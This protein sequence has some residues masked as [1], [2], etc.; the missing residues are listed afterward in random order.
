VVWFAPCAL[1]PWAG[2]STRRYL[3]FLIIPYLACAAVGGWLS[4]GT[5]V[6][7]A[8]PRLDARGTA[9]EEKRLG[10]ALRARGVKAAYAQYWLAYRLTFLWHEDPVVIPLGGDRHPEYRQQLRDQRTVA[11]IFHPSEPRA[12]PKDVR[13]RLRTGTVETQQIEGFTVL[14]HHR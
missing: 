2:W 8:L 11:Y 13:P 7:G 9:V 3:G 14:T 12:T 5:Y 10:E 4:Y 1:A 6:D